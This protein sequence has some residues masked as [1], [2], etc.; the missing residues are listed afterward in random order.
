[1]KKYIKILNIAYVNVFHYR[2]MFNAMYIVINVI[3]KLQYFILSHHLKIYLVIN[4]QHLKKVCSFTNCF[5]QRLT[6]L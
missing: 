2:Q 6:A 4:M 5:L 3:I 1:M